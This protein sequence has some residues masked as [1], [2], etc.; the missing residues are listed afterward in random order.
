M[1]LEMI[2]QSMV[3]ETE[4]DKHFIIWSSSSKSSDVSNYLGIN[5]D[6]LEG[7]LGLYGSPPKKS[8]LC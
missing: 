7:E 1:E 5:T 2:I 4:E 8:K 3:T 6:D